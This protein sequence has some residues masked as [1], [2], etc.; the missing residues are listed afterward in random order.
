VQRR[1]VLKP[2]R[3]KSLLQRHPWI[4]SGAIASIPSIDPGEILP[5]YS[6]SEEFLALAYFH[7]KNSLAGRI[8][9]FTQEPIEQILEKN[10]KRALEL[11]ASFFSEAHT[12]AFRLV[13]AES[14]GLP[15]LIVDRYADHLVIQINTWGMERLKPFLIEKLRELLSPQSIYEKS[16]SSAR[17]LEGLG[18]QTGLV[19]GEEV[20]EIEILERG[21]RFIVAIR[22]G[23]K[24]GFFLDQREMRQKVETLSR[25]RRVLNCFSYTGG[26]SLFALRGGALF[27]DSVEIC[28]KANDLAQRNTD[29]NGF[30]DHRIHTEDAFAFLRR[31][32]LDY[33]LIIL[34]PPAFAKKR[35]DIQAACRGYKEINRSVLEK[36]PRGALLLSSSCSFY[37]D[38]K[39]FQTLLFQAACEAERAVK[40]I[41]CS[42]VSMDHAASIYHPEGVYLKSSLLFLQ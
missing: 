27:V 15:G 41:R 36:A 13:N 25:G 24:T 32:R 10:L 7:P 2:G 18:D 3:E 19:W 29:L 1:V 34:D 20:D 35:E 11:R 16:C 14:D 23:Q 8:L 39:L 33:D 22:E 6:A 9:S 31:S 12:N 37:I 40:F 42:P 30:T 5:V 4:F 26:F 17:R 28:S 21:M 38:E